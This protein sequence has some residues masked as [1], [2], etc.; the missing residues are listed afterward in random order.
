MAAAVQR[1]LPLQLAFANIDPLASGLSISQ[2]HALDSLRAK[3]IRDVGGPNQ[4]PADPTYSRRWQNAQ[5]ANDAELRLCFGADFVEQ[6]ALQAAQEEQA[7]IWR[8]P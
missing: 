8:S 2:A 3:F 6:L 5:P 4:N 7:A 1:R